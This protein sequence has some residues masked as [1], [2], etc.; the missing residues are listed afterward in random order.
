MLLLNH[1]IFVLSNKNRKVN[2]LVLFLKDKKLKKLVVALKLLTVL[3]L[4]SN[5]FC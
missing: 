4:N 5:A 1:H 3:S 2:K